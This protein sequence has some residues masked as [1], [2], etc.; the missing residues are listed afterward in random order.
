M[1]VIQNSFYL[2]MFIGYIFN[3]IIPNSS[4]FIYNSKLKKIKIISKQKDY[5]IIVYLRR[6]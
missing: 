6:L 3:H 5:I 2:D 1:V 4:L